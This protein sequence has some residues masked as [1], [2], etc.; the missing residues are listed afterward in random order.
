MFE[1]T[2]RELQRFGTFLVT[3][4]KKKIKEKI[5]PYGNPVREGKVISLLQDNFI[6]L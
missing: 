2:D 1:L 5:Y 6:I 4:M 3:L